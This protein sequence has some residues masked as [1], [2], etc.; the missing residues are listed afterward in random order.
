[1]DFQWSFVYSLWFNQVCSVC[2]NN[3]F[4]IYGTMFKYVPLT[5]GHIWWLIETKVVLFVFVLYTEFKVYCVSGLSIL[6]WSFCFSLTFLLSHYHHHPNQPIF[7]YR[8]FLYMR[9][10]KIVNTNHSFPFD[11]TRYI[12]RRQTGPKKPQH[13]CFNQ[14]VL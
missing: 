12:E 4:S 6:D 2:K 1:L 13:S 7:A 14:L 11:R 9:S 8:H 3:T 10:V 5:V